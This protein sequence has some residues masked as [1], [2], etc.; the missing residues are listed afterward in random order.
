MVIKK[1]PVFQEIF[2]SLKKAVYTLALFSICSNILMLTVPI[3]M[4]QLYDNILSS[5]S[6]SSLIYLTLIALFALMIYGVIELMRSRIL[7]II[8]GWLDK[9]LSPRALARSADELLQGRTYGSQALRDIA[10]IRTFIGS[11]GIFAIFDSPW[12]PIYLLVI[13][14]LH[15]VLGVLATLGSIALFSLGIAN[16]LVTRNILKQANEKAIVIQ[17]HTENSLSN[18]EVIQ[19]MGMMPAIIKQWHL[20]NDPVVQLQKLASDRGGLINSVTKFLRLAMQLLMLG[21]GAYLVIVDQVT[22]GVMIAGTILLARAL[23]PVEQAIG[24]WKLLQSAREGYARLKLHFATDITRSAGIQLPEPKGHVRLENVYYF[25]PETTKPIINNVSLALKPGEIV[26]MIG[27]SGAG[28]STLARLMVGVW[29]AS[30]GNVRLDGADVY[31]WDRHEF[32]PH[33]GYLAQEVQLFPGTI[34]ENIA[35]LNEGD[36]AAIIKAAQLAGAHDLILHFPKGYDTEIKTGRFSLSG[37]QQQR[38]ALA[39]ALYKDPVLYVLDEPN[40]HLDSA[41]E[42]A[43][44]QALLFLKSQNKTVFVISHRPEIL[45]HVDRIIVL[46]EGSIQIEGKRDEVLARLQQMVQHQTQQSLQKN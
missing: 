6:F 24:S 5:R 17:R 25:V 27:P 41:G 21:V 11:P 38:I 16:E 26:A 42:R 19:A 31:T 45:K 14:L 22:S 35:R 36:D 10:T 29:R 9:H 4:L 13:Y 39:R 37:G 46:S 32:G 33:I 40:A 34:K 43:L 7:V 2:G 23:A 18:A 44:I 12:V 8:S 30:R 15:P 3:Y 20:K 1:S 28:K